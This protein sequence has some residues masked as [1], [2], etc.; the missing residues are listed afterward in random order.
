MGVWVHGDGKGA[1]LNLKRQSPPHITGAAGD[2]Y[3]ILDFTG[4]R[5]VELVEPEGERFLDYRWPYAGWYSVFR[6]TPRL[7]AVDRLG[8]LLAN[9][10]AGETEVHLGPVRAIPL[11]SPL[12]A[13]GRLTVNGREFPMPFALG[14]GQSL[15]L[16]ADGW[17]RLL[18]IKGETLRAM[19][20]AEVPTIKAGD[21]ELAFACAAPVAGERVRTK[22]TVF[23]Q[24]DPLPGARSEAAAGFRPERDI[25]P[26]WT[27][28]A[29]VP[30]T[31]RW[32]FPC[33]GE[34]A[35]LEVRLRVLDRQ[36]QV[37]RPG[38]GDGVVLDDFASLAAFA[39]SPDNQFRQYV[40]SGALVNVDAPLSVSHAL[41]ATERVPGQAAVL[42]TAR[43]EQAG[44]WCARGRRFSPPLDLAG[45]TH[46]GYWLRGDGRGEVLYVQLRDTAGRHL[47]FKTT[48][49]FTDWRYLEFALKAGEFDLGHT[50]YAIVYFNGLPAGQ[51][52]ACGLDD[53]RA[54]AVQDALREPVIR[55]NDG[56][57]RIR[58]E[59]PAGAV[60]R[61]MPNGE[62]TCTA[63]DG[64]VRNLA[65]DGSLSLRRGWNE[66]EVRTEGESGL[67]LEVVLIKHDPV[68]R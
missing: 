59:L 9:L 3:V 58:G 48:V 8:V 2:H 27:V 56:T 26:P 43:S 1:V 47:D 63:A 31:R 10:P 42:Y 32:R 15:E 67:D 64:T 61:C 22:I 54:F 17:L 57:L 23:T 21:N 30:E 24:G 5:W 50:E 34:D 62:T 46:L 13:E 18:G 37:S 39:D 6:Q 52:V 68:G 25:E 11:A 53:L 4:W 60:L 35:E 20:V 41:S 65:V 29:G 40:R 44:G 28:L 38:A 14:V 36:P 19:R 49:D 16:A 55:V 66:I 12:V 51:E 45:C 7:D 33:A